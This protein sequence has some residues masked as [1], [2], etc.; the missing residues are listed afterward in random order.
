MKKLRENQKQ[1]KQDRLNANQ[2]QTPSNTLQDDIKS[3]DYNQNIDIDTK[4]QDTNN[5]ETTNQDINDNIQDQI[6]TQI[7]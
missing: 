5:P 3:A 1:Q 7:E 4:N 2:P 6:Q